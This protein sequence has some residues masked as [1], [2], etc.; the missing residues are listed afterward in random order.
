MEK[1]GDPIVA[2]FIYLTNA[3]VA[4]LEWIVSN[5]V[6]REQDRDQ[7]VDLLITSAEEKGEIIGLE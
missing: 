4:L 7:A 5:P 1:N 6:Y 2:G 3:K